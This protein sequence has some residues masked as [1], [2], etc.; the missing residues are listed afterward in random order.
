MQEKGR[1]HVWRGIKVIAGLALLSVLSVSVC[2][3][4]LY[5][6]RSPE[7]PDVQEVPTPPI[8]MTVSP[9]A[10][11]P[12]VTNLQVTAPQM[13]DPPATEPLVR[14]PAKHTRTPHPADTQRGPDPTPEPTST[15]S[16]RPRATPRADVK[17]TPSAPAP[18]S[19]PPKPSAPIGLPSETGNPGWPEL[20]H[21]EPNVK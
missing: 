9:S 21:R 16:R 14:I 7:R 1:D 8:R 15:P 18:V 19:S 20:K 17:A 13:T 4:V 5:L 10:T 11:H 3:A 12:R 2:A 6:T